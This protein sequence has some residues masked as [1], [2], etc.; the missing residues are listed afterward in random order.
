MVFVSYSPAT[1]VP[2]V[3]MLLQGH[4]LPSICTT[5]GYSFSVQSL[6]IWNHLFELTWVVIRNPADY[7]VWGRSK[8]LSSEDCQFMIELVKDEICLF[9]AEIQEK[10]YDNREE[11]MSVQAVHNNLVNQLSITLKN[12]KTVN[13]KKCLL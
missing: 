11:L 7:E 8:L 3:Q 6:Y 12:G 4:Y 10:L 2:V 5:L 13:I 9:L 1:N